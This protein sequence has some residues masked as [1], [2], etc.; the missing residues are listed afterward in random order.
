MRIDSLTIRWFP[1]FVRGGFE[2]VDLRD[3]AIALRSELAINGLSDSLVADA[4][5]WL[6]RGAST[7]FTDI[8]GKEAGYI[9]A[10]LDL[11]TGP[12]ERI[13]KDP[14]A[15]TGAK[16]NAVIALQYHMTDDGF[17]QAAASALCSLSARARGVTA[18]LGDPGMPAREALSD[19]EL[20]LLSELVA[21]LERYRPHGVLS[22]RQMLDVSNPVGRFVQSS[23]PSLW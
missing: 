21:A 20:G 11:P 15:S 22:L 4:F 19:D 16:F 14:S 12:V 23:V 6:V 3:S 18:V 10:A 2:H 9:Y 5:V 17:A 13:I 7:G 8:Q 1:V